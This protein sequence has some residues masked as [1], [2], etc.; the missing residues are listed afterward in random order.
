M[1]FSQNLQLPYIVYSFIA[2]YSI[3]YSYP[4]L[5]VSHDLL[6]MRLLKLKDDGGFGLIEFFGV[7]IRASLSPRILRGG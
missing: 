3:S 5:E 1:S 6:N 2:W 7:N 4:S